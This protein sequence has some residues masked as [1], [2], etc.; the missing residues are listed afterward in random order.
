V[1]DRG[2]QVADRVGSEDV[3]G[4]PEGEQEH[5]AVS[6]PGDQRGGPVPAGPVEQ[7]T[8]DDPGG[9]RRQR[10]AAA[11]DDR[12]QREPEQYIDGTV[13]GT[14]DIQR[15]CPCRLFSPDPATELAPAVETSSKFLA[16]R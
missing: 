10:P 7:D 16:S 12:E 13:Y 1:H 9:Q 6:E 11:Q 2:E 4:E 8:G 3:E 15:E 5:G 14:A